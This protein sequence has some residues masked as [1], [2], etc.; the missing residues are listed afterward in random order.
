MKSKRLR[1]LIIIGCGLSLIFYMVFQVNSIAVTKYNIPIENLPSSFEGFTILHLTDLHSK[2]YGE[3]QK[4]LLDLIDRNKFDIIVITGDII[5]KNN[6]DINSAV[7][8][9]NGL[10]VPVFFVP[11]NHEWLSGYDIRD[12][13][14]SL[15]VQ[16]LENDNYKFIR[17]DDHIWI[18]GVDDPYLGKDNLDL[19]LEG[20]D[21]TSSRLLLA[22]DPTILQSAVNMVDLVMAGHT[23]GGQIRLP[24]IGGL[25]V[26]GQGFF[27]QYDYGLYYEESTFMVINGGLGESVLPIRFFNRP[28]IVLIT[29]E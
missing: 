2:E 21:Y 16:I 14:I 4:R 13:L 26:P 9:I 18:I 20:I 29:L 27:P 25:F 24:V 15:N 5:D 6:P 28:E 17:G 1:W 10:T 8:L 23:H 11:G 12:P 19:A 7:S 22:H 3:N